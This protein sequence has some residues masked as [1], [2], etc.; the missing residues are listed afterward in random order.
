MIAKKARG[1][2]G[3]RDIIDRLLDSDE[4]PPVEPPGMVEP[5]VSE[6]TIIEPLVEPPGIVEP[7][8]FEPPVSEPPILPSIEIPD[9]DDE[10]PD[11][12]CVPYKDLTNFRRRVKAVVE[13]R[14]PPHHQVVFNL[15]APDQDWQP[16]LDYIV[17]TGLSVRHV[18]HFKFGITYW[19]AHR[20]NKWDYRSLRLM[21]VSLVTEDCNLT[22]A[23]EKA[24]IARYR[25]DHRCRNVSPGGESHDHHV[26]PHF[27]Y[28]VFGNLHTF[29]RKR[30]QPYKARSDSSNQS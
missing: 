4:E 6:P 17:N 24:A 16:H 9:S 18:T 22:A 14:F 11:D 13:A 5:P 1:D 23:A 28:V 26:S 30:S 29:P 12:T 25:V 27:L 21:I 8:V 3:P 20:F 10:L 19:P 2:T 7:R 15:A